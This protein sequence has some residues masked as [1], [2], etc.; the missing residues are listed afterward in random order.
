MS[1]FELVKKRRSIRQFKPEKIESE[2]IKLITSAG[3]MAPSS[4][5]CKPCEF[6]VVEN[7]DTLQKLSESRPAS[8]QLIANAAAAIVIC[9]DKNKSTCP[10]EDATIAA[11]MMQLEAEDINLGSCWVHI[12]ARE[13]EPGLTSENY[14]KKTLG[15]A[16]NYAVLCIIALGYKNEE[17]SHHDEE[18]LDSNKIHYEKF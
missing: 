13:K 9:I 7:K 1:F 3:L 2:K 14:V 5:N 12:H 11:I 15:I 10:V 8:S 4:R 6:V 18:K 16:D 17:K